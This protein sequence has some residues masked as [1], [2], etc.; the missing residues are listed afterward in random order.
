[1]I[2]FLTEISRY[3]RWS[4]V[5]FSWS[6]SGS[7]ISQGCKHKLSSLYD[8]LLLVTHLT[9]TTWHGCNI[10]NEHLPRRSHDNLGI[11]ERVY[12]WSNLSMY[13]FLVASLWILSSEWVVGL[14]VNKTVD[15][16]Y[17]QATLE[18]A[19]SFLFI[20]HSWQIR[21]YGL[22]LCGYWFQAWITEFKTSAWP[23]GWSR[24]EDSVVSHWE[25]IIWKEFLRYTGCLFKRTT[26]IFI[27]AGRREL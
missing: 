4:Q 23:Q 22:L 20:S 6:M 1:M 24:A 7:A 25:I 14:S 8:R 15:C 5:L 3:R 13:W 21:P 12:W 26:L 2:H 9:Q 11:N 18:G 17:P 19:C 10:D 16:F 27:K